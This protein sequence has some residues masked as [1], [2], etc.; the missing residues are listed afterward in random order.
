MQSSAFGAG[1]GNNTT[2]APDSVGWMTD[3]V[4]HLGKSETERNPNAKIKVLVPPAVLKVASDAARHIGA[5]F[6]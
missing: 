4:N 5:L 2:S 1:K 6:G 3:F